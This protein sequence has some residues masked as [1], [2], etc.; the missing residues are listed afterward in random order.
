MKHIKLFL[1]YVTINQGANLSINTTPHQVTFDGGDG[2][3]SMDTT[4]TKRVVKSS[5]IKRGNNAK[6]KQDY[7]KKKNKKQTKEISTNSMSKNLINTSN[8]GDNGPGNSPGSGGASYA[9]QGY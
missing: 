1:E 4:P 7:H 5:K 6:Q 2:P 3:S 9:T 8:F